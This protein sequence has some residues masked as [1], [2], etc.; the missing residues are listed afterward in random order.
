MSAR[1]AFCRFPVAVVLTWLAVAVGSTQPAPAP[2]APG[3]VPPHIVACNPEPFATNVSADL[4]EVSVT[5]DRPMAANSGFTGL[6]FLGVY[7][8]ARD[9]QPRWDATGT[10]CT[11]PV[12]LAPDVTYALAANTSKDRGFA[13]RSAVPALAFAWIFATGERTE[14]QLPPRVVKSDPPLGATDVDFR[15]RQISV[16][17]NRPVAPGDFSWTLQRGSG[18]YPGTRGGAMTLSDDRL[19]ATIEVRLSPG[20]VYALS[21]NDLY[22]CGYKDTYGRPVVPYGWWFKTA[23]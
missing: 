7:P 15:L 10:T 19:T 11:L 23:D 17:F 4:K 2:Q 3:L 16:A 9:A 5:F 18:E 8:A 20:T 1:V 13:D 12:E 21:L 14:E 22:Y 6:R